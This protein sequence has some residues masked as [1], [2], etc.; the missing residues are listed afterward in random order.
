MIY[1][2][3]IKVFLIRTISLNILAILIGWFPVVFFWPELSLK[4]LMPASCVF[5]AIACVGS[6]FIYSEIIPDQLAE[7]ILKII[8]EKAHKDD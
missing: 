4:Y 8:K 7:Q 6:R 5:G 3:K 2:K 1:G